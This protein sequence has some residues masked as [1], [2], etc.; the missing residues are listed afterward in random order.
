MNVVCCFI[1]E[2]FTDNAPFNLEIL[3]NAYVNEPHPQ[4]AHKYSEH[5]NPNRHNYL[6]PSFDSPLHSLIYPLHQLHYRHVYR[7]LVHRYLCAYDAD[8]EIIQCFEPLYHS[9][10]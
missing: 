2:V 5:F 3:P 6:L 8:K 9:F 7:V 10:I 4:R 1:F